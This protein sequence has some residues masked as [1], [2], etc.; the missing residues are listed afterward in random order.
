MH[1]APADTFSRHIHQDNFS[2]G[3]A[4]ELIFMR[5]DDV[6]SIFLKF[7]KKSFFSV[8]VIKVG[9]ELGAAGNVEFFENPA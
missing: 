5:I 1:E 4:P 7:I 9:E 3:S 6:H 2:S 8:G